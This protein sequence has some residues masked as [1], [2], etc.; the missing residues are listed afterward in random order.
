MLHPFHCLRKTQSLHR[1]FTVKVWCF[2]DCW[3]CWRVWQPKYNWMFSHVD[4]PQ[5]ILPIDC[6]LQEANV[7]VNVQYRVWSCSNKH[8]P[9]CCR[10]S[11]GLWAYLQNAEGDEAKG[12]STPG[13]LPLKSITTQAEKDGEYWAF[14][15]HRRLLVRARPKKQSSL[16]DPSSCQTIPL[17]IH[18]LGNA[19]TTMMITR[20][21]IDSTQGHWRKKWRSPMGEYWEGKA[22]FRVY[23]WALGGRLQSW[24]SRAQGSTH[25]LGSCWYGTHGGQRGI[26]ISPEEPRRSVCRRQSGDNSHSGKW[27]VTN[28]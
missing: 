26:V 4:R 25:R 7:R 14:I 24:S 10:S 12:N 15:R 11:S 20:A 6:I 23:V 3:S 19:R 2:A 8:I 27:Q 1:G 13:G 5:S 9:A 28:F 18:R 17:P 22:Y 21:G 16:F